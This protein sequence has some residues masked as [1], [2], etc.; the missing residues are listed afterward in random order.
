MRYRLLA[1]TGSP[2]MPTGIV[3]SGFHVTGTLRISTAQSSVAEPAGKR[4]VSSK[5]EECAGSR[6]RPL[7]ALA[8]LAGFEFPRRL[9]RDVDGFGGVVVRDIGPPIGSSDPVGRRV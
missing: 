7:R 2:L 4:V 3:D 5:K 9:V 6:E 1:G 8:W